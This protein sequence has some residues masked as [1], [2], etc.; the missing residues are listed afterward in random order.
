M[1]WYRA[2]LA[3]KSVYFQQLYKSEIFCWHGA[4]QKVYIF[5]NHTKV[6]FLLVWSPSSLKK[7]IFSQIVHMWTFLLAWSPYRLKKCIC[8]IIVQSEH[9]WW[10]RAHLASKSVYFQQLYKSEHF[11]LYAAPLASKSVYFQ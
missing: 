3:S 11:C 8:S 5:N 6:K 9:I 7:Y 1:Y 4:P 10:Y 2:H